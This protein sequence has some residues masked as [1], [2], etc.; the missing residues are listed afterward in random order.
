MGCVTSYQLK[1]AS[2]DKHNL[3]S[4][5]DT[6]KAYCCKVYDGDTI[7][8]LRYYKKEIIKIKIRLNNIDT[9]EMKTVKEGLTAKEIL[10]GLILNKIIKVKCNGNDKFGRTLGIIYI[11]NNCVNDMLIKEGFAKEYHGEK[12]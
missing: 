10:T 5:N 8:I 11:D 7:H 3:F 2:N 12:K 9:P 1:M 4:F 6:C